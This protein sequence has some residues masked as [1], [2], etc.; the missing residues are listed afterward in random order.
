MILL[1]FLVCH[2]LGYSNED[3]LSNYSF[4]I[5]SSCQFDYD[6]IVKYFDTHFCVKGIQKSLEYPNRV[7]D[8]VMNCDFDGQSLNQ[9]DQFKPR[10]EFIHRIIELMGIDTRLL[11]DATTSMGQAGVTDYLSP[12]MMSLI[13]KHY[14]KCSPESPS[15]QKLEFRVANTTFDGENEQEDKASHR[16]KFLLYSILSI[17]LMTFIGWIIYCRVYRLADNENSMKYLNKIMI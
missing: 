17:V 1:P 10:D 14:S 6:P 11:E 4:S 2:V 7:V 9:R 3:H 13:S 15:V 8:I 16:N 5:S 12:T